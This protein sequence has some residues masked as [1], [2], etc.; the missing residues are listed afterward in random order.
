MLTQPLRLAYWSQP[1]YARLA[2]I[3]DVGTIHL[4]N[5]MFAV[6]TKLLPGWVEVP[7]NL[8]DERESVDLLLNTGKVE[9]VSDTAVAAAEK[10]AKAAD[11]L[12]A[13]QP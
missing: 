7:L 8:L 1:E 10:I 9:V 11:Y 4:V 3:F 13:C 2:N 5:I 6:F 12:R